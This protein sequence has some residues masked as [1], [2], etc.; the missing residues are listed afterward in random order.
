MEFPLGQCRRPLAQCLLCA[1][2]SLGIE[3]KVVRGA[4]G[5]GTPKTVQCATYTAVHDSL[6]MGHCPWLRDPEG[7]CQN[8]GSSSK[9][10]ESPPKLEHDSSPSEWVP[11]AHGYLVAAAPSPYRNFHAEVM[12]KVDIDS[13][14]L[15][16]P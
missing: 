13:V 8:A 16:R 3:C 4:V 5:N 11:V 14:R 6:V 12:Q 7:G 10:S 1:P 9:V 15:V 2:S